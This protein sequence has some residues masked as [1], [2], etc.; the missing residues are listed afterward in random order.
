[1]GEA[2]LGSLGT[3]SRVFKWLTDNVCEVSKCIEFFPLAR[4]FFPNLPG[5]NIVS[6]YL[7]IFFS[8]FILIFELKERQVWERKK[9]PEVE[10]DS[11]RDANIWLVKIGQVMCAH[12]KK[13]NRL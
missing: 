2:S 3:F 10:S 1:M 4:T 8:L 11:S 6:Y 13:N 7:F 12:V 9:N 5:L